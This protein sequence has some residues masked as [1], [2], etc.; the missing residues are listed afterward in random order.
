VSDARV[1]GVDFSGAKRPGESIWITEARLGDGLTVERCR[2][3]G[4]TLGERGRAAVLS[5]LVD[6]VDGAAVVGFD[7]PFGLP[8]PVVETLDGPATWSETV[9]W[10]RDEFPD[11][12]TFAERC[13]SAAQTATDGD[14]TYLKRATDGPVGAKSPYH[15]FTFRQAYHG[16][17]E[18]L[19]PLLGR[20]VAV[21]PMTV[22]RR[23]GGSRERDHRRD[24]RPTVVEAYPAGTLRRLDLPA[25]RYKDDTEPARSRRERILAGVTEDEAVSV[26]RTARTA[27][28]SDP[29]GDA[30]DSLVAAVA[31]ARALTTAFRVAADRY[32]PLEGY[33]YV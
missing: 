20:E 23:G 10:V 26:A 11:A 2:A 24:G 8:R 17:G 31:A 25:E 3:A 30:L 7:F 5:A 9:T 27:A 18:V 32:D 19:A 22:D 14:R 33:V 29:G 13:Q 28:L 4:E 12:E 16:V 6:H 1:L 15:F 21:A